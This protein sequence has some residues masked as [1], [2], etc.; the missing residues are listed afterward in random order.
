MMQIAELIIILGSPAS[1]K[2][3]LARRLAQHLALPC[4]CKDDVKEALFDAIETGNRD[5]SRRLSEASFAVLARLACA[6]LAGGRSLIL[7]GNWRAAHLPFFASA[8]GRARVRQIGCQADPA[9]IVRRFTQ[10]QRHPGHLDAEAPLADLAKAASQGPVFLDLPGERHVYASDDP[11]A[12][13]A[14]VRALKA[15]TL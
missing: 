1:G 8:L 11:R 15:T 6:E 4:L 7:E 5:W 2:T 3:T 14:L 12:Y 9:E 13:E 10:R